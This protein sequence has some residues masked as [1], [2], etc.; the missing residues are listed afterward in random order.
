MRPVLLIAL[1]LCLPAGTVA[2]KPERPNILFIVSDDQ[3]ATALGCAGNE[4]I[5]TPNL[6]RLA[7]GGVRFTRCFSP[8]PIC[9]PS[10][11]CI[12]TGQDSWT[13]GCTFFGKPIRE[14]SP[15]WPRLLME[16]GYATFYT[17]KWHNRGLPH[18]HGFSCGADIYVGGKC[19]HAELPVVQYGQPRKTR[20]LADK[21]SSK[22]FADAAIRFLNGRRPGDPPFCVYLAFT[23]PHDPWIPP[24]RYATMYQAA[25]MPVPV[26]FAPRPPFKMHPSFP[27]LR[28][29]KQLPFPRTK[30]D[31]RQALTQY[32]GMITHMDVQI[33]RVLDTLDR[34]GLARDTLVIFVSD[35]GYSLG[36]HGFVG[37]QTMYD[38]GIVTP[39][40]LRYPRL[41][42]GK[43][44]NDALVS[45][46]DLFP[47]ICESAGVGVP[48]EVEGQSLLQ[49]YQ[50]AG[51]WPR[52]HVFSSFHSPTAHYMST[53]CIRTGRHKLI[54][55]LL[56]GETEL[57]DLA[58]DPHELK[59]LAGRPELAALQ[60]QLTQKLMA[61][62][63][64][65]KEK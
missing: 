32:Y 39:L 4:A 10:R 23:A 52:E 27:A 54:Q 15:R 36:A 31:V 5:E 25:K 65:A 34:L 57:F 41:P 43:S 17:G 55:H 63:Q 44:T 56:T 40:I 60:Q 3:M 24:G 35:Q 51:D 14:S 26:N 19:N 61:W 11:A 2:A 7:A 21:F 59:N 33:G 64:G 8:N 45:L 18:E 9:E 22:L 62:R 38:E 50:G 53:R 58:L 28:D 12:L 47:T 30:A 20:K 16:A 46:V 37:K 48:D 29:Q 13:N 6:D 1:T 42:R 49:L